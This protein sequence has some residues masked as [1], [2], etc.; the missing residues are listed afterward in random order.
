MQDVDFE[1]NS[2]SFVSVRLKFFARGF[3]TLSSVNTKI[4]SSPHIQLQP[5][6]EV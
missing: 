3:L 6:L 4:T 1:E 2:H 5:A